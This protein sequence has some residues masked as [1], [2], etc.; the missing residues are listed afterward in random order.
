MRMMLF[1]TVAFAPA[2][3]HFRWVWDSNP[4]DPLMFHSLLPLHRES[5]PLISL[6]LTKPPD[7]FSG[8]ITSTN[9]FKRF[10]RN[11]MLSTSIAMINT[12]YHTS[13]RL[14]TKFGY[15]CKRRVSPGPIGSFTHFAMGLILSPRLW[16]VM[17]LSSTLHPSLVYI[18]YSTWTSFDHIFHHYLTLLRSQNH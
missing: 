11:P 7:S 13:F 4:W 5:L 8:F 17:L 1:R 2:I 6:Q 3:T 12:G 16:V 15:I 10:C 14:V 18:Q 9:R